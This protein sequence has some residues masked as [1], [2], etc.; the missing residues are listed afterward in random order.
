MFGDALA[1]QLKVTL[2]DTRAMAVKF[3]PVTAAP[4][5]FTEA[6][7]GVNVYPD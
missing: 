1:A 2:C 4:F 3:T 6:V 7:D 5:T